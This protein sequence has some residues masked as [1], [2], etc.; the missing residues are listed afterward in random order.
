MPLETVL[1]AYAGLA[2]LAA[3]RGRT[4]HRPT[5]PPFV[6]SRPAMRIVGFALLLLS[7]AT[8]FAH[9]GRYQGVV[10]WLGLLSLSGVGL[11]LLLSRWR[12]IAI[13][14]WLPVATIGLLLGLVNAVTAA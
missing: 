9:F 11:V 4:P 5:E 8:A 14:M 10:A 2:L 3:V 12:D 13:A 1:L 7:L 6:T